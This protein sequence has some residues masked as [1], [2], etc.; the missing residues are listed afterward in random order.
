[1]TD[2]KRRTIKKQNHAA[3]TGR[4]A[5]VGLDVGTGA[6]L[7]A[8]E[9]LRSR[10]WDPSDSQYRVQALGLLLKEG[11]TLDAEKLRRLHAYAGE[12]RFHA[13]ISLAGPSPQGGAGPILVREGAYVFVLRPPPPLEAAYLQPGARFV[14]IEDVER[15]RPASGDRRQHSGKK[16]GEAPPRYRCVFIDTSARG[17]IASFVP[18]DAKVDPGEQL[19]P[20]GSRRV[21][22]ALA[23]AEFARLG[24]LREEP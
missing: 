17:P 14:R 23:Y 4:A 2:E 15:L 18:E 12:T 20:K 21:E 9:L 5:G 7:R 10:G 19:L 16:R 1:M 3:L 24:A 8:K 22:L 6:T 13:L 11:G